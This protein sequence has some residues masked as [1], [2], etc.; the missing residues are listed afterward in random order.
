MDFKL[1]PCGYPPLKTKTTAFQPLFLFLFIDKLHKSAEAAESHHEG[2]NFFQ[3]A[4]VVL[5]QD[6]CVCC[7][8]R[9]LRHLFAGYATS[10]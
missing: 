8:R 4:H 2:R 7:R 9:L 5:T 10:V 1:F 3:L 6:D